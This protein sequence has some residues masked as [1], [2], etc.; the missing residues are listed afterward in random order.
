MLGGRI[1]LHATTKLSDSSQFEMVKREF[2]VAADAKLSVEGVPV[3]GGGGVGSLELEHTNTASATQ[4]FKSLLMVLRGGN[5]SLGDLR[6]SG[7]LGTKWIASLAPD[8]EWK[9][10]GFYDNSLVPIIAF[11]PEKTGATC[12]SAF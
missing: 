11:L 2:K 5:E 4:Q 7:Q 1:I 9:L 8:P 12:A 3:E 10:F 6:E